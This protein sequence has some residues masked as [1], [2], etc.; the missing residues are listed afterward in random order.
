[1][2]QK[3][4][5]PLVTATKYPYFDCVVLFV[6]L[7]AMF[8]QYLTRVCKPTYFRKL[9]S[10]TPKY[11]GAKWTLR[12]EQIFNLQVQNLWTHFYGTF[13]L[14]LPLLE[15]GGQKICTFFSYL[16]QHFLYIY[17]LTIYQQ[18]LLHICVASDT[19]NNIEKY[20]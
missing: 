13:L 18:G 2:T 14:T 5:C 6:V 17:I 19:W 20:H 1:V 4:L 7:G 11:F 16:A 8:F 15:H 9:T 3:E 12:S 10:P